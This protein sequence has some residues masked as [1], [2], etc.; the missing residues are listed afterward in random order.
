MEALV[1]ETGLSWAELV[2]NCTRISQKASLTAGLAKATW[3]V[4]K[5]GPTL[6]R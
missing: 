3:S 5:D 2:K 1:A 6:H 4:R